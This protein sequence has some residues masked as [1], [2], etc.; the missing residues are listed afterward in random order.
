MEREGSYS[1][2]SITKPF[3]FLSEN[4]AKPIAE[5][6]PS[7]RPRTMPSVGIYRPPAARKLEQN[8]ADVVCR[9]AHPATRRR[10]SENSLKPEASSPPPM[11]NVQVKC[12]RR[13]PIFS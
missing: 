3:F 1:Y 9:S 11:S 10:S 12:L 5:V 8:A 4:L 13:K 6:Q 7:K 2:L